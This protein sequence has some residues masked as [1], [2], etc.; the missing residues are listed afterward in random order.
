MEKVTC[1]SCY[2]RIK[3]KLSDKNKV[4]LIDRQGEYTQG[5]AFAIYCGIMNQLSHIV[6]RGKLYLIAPFQRKETILII[7]AIVSL[8]GIVMIGDPK[9]TRESFVKQIEDIVTIDAFVPFEEDK[10]F[11][12]INGKKTEIVLKEE[13]LKA[14]PFLRVRKKEPSFYFY[15]AGSTGTNKIVA[16]SDYSFFNNIARQETNDGNYKGVGYLCLPLNH[17][18]GISTQMQYFLA[19]HPAY[20][21]DTRA[22]SFALDIIEKYHC[23]TI[24]NVPTFYYMLINEQHNKPRDI[25]SLKEKLPRSNS[26]SVLAGSMIPFLW[27]SSA[28]TSK[29][30]LISIFQFSSWM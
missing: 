15:T 16:L 3:E 25:S 30:S 29:K 12:E 13:S 14:K 1:K 5:Q 27:R 19:G 21:S 7:A 9:E 22:A 10:W 23:T 4:L 2:V 20:I 8:G 28:S 11:L 18:F 17:I 6:K 24:P 26:P